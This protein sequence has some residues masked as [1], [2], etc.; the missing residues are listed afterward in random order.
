ML[1]D[2]RG[3]RI[4]ILIPTEYY[5]E[6]ES[7]DD[8]VADLEFHSPEGHVM[9]TIDLVELAQK[10]NHIFIELLTINSKWMFEAL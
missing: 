9:K 2:G 7:E 3:R 5:G 8:A 6:G 10:R 1:L 4:P